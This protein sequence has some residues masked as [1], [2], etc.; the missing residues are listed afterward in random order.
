MYIPGLD[1]T[2]SVGK[3]RGVES[4]GMMASEREMGLSDEHDGIIELPS[5]E[6]GEEFAHWL[7]VNRPPLRRTA[8]MRWACGA[9]RGIWRRGGS[10][11]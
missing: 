8:P 1:I 3:I 5:G 4:H 2:I 10:A 6:I 9:W 7:S 11:R